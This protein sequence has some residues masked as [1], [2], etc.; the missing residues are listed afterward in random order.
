MGQRLLGG[1]DG[2]QTQLDGAVA[3]GMDGYRHVVAVSLHHHF[4]QL[5]GREEQQ[6]PGGGIVGIGLAQIGRPGAQRAVGQQLDAGDLETAVA[7]AVVPAVLVEES[8]HFF[9]TIHQ[10]LFRH[11]QLED[12]LVGS[13]PD[14]LHHVVSAAVGEVFEVVALDGGNAA[15][16]QVGLTGDQLIQQLIQTGGGQIALDVV[17]NDLLDHAVG[18]A[19]GPPFGVVA[20]LSH[21]ILVDAQQLHGL[22][23]E[24][25]HMETGTHHQNGIF[26]GDGIQIPV[27]GETLFI[28]EAVLVPAFA[29][30]P[31]A[32]V[33]VI[34]VFKIVLHPLY[35]IGHGGAAEKL[36]A[37]LGLDIV[38]IVHMAVVE[39]GQQELA[40]A[41]DLPQFLLGML[42]QKGG[43]TGFVAHIGEVFIND[44]CRGGGRAGFVHGGDVGMF[45]PKRH[46][47]HLLHILYIKDSIAAKARQG[48]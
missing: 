36:G 30:H 13:L 2:I 26:G 44:H 23:V 42:L 43:G 32:G 38:H 8:L 25:T 33:F 20:V 39:A 21:G 34:T 14:T 4:L 45:D 15:F 3:D 16:K 46:K 35:Q 17:Q 37:H 19:V 27:G 5:F 28:G 7:K 40:A 9:Q 1:L 11:A 6:T 22:G 10:R 12:A 29:H 47:K 48:N 31:Q 24:G 41:V 18:R